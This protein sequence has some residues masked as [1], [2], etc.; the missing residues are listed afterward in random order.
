MTC[1]VKFFVGVLFSFPSG[2]LR[3]FAACV[4]FCSC[5]VSVAS[6]FQDMR[7]LLPKRS[8][9]RFRLSPSVVIFYCRGLPVAS[10]FRGMRDLL[11]KRSAGRF[12]LSLTVVIFCCPGLPV[13]LLF[14][15]IRDL[16]LPKRPW[17]P[18]SLFHVLKRGK[19]FF[20]GADFN[21]ME[22]IVDKYLSIADVAGIEGFAGCFDD[23][24]H[25][26][27]RDDD[28]Y[29]DLG[30]EGSV[31][32]SASIAFAGS[33]LDAA[34]HDLGHGHTGHAQLVESL[35]EFIKLVEAADNG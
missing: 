32:D 20:A 8:A 12:R 10:L 22:N 16:S 13:V 15:G 23:L 24:I 2:I 11:P 9:G 1:F 17:N 34:A 30:Q 25:R 7:D 6:L 21:D 4:T 29:L 3:F 33:S 18:R 31:D 19:V 26:N 14:H 35:L 27:L 28:F 5:S